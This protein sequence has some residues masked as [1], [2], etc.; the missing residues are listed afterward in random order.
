MCES[1]DAATG[2]GLVIELK[3]ELRIGLRDG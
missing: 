1:V 2:L 3:L